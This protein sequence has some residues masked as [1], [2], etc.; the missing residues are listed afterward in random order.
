MRSGGT[1]YEPTIL[2]DVTPDMNCVA[3]EEIFGPVAP[4]FRF[5]TEAEV[6]KLAND[7]PFGPAAYFYSRDLGPRVWRVA[8]AL[9]Y[10]IVGINEGHRSFERGRALRRHQGIR[11]RPRRVR[12]MGIEDYLEIKYTLMGG[13]WA[14][15]KPS[16]IGR[17]RTL[18]YRFVSRG[19]SGR[20]S[21]KN[22]LLKVERSVNTYHAQNVSAF[23]S[24][25]ERAVG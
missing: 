5:K 23:Q 17:T 9:E 16:Q 18:Y 2:G 4:L 7:T 14:P 8:E 19:S 13:L 11:Q 22:S 10:G 24:R 6:I 1:F 25:S 21:L 3:M 20:K 12:S 15:D